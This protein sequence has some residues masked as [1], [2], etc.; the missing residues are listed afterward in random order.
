MSVPSDSFNSLPLTLSN[1]GQTPN[2][3]RKKYSKN[4][5]LFISIQFLSSSQT[6][7]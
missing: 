6:M 4:I 7:A 3:G 2:K 1:K 5:F